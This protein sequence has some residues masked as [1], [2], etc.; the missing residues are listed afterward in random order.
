MF[1]FGE[2]RTHLGVVSSDAFEVFEVLSWISEKEKKK[3]QK[4]AKI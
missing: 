1:G 3:G 4:S 2:V